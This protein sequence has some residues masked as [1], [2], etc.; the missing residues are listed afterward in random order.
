[1]TIENREEYKDV[2]VSAFNFS[3]RTYN[4][5]KRA[6]L[7]S[8][9]QVIANYDSLPDIRNMGKKS[10]D[11]I[12]EMLH[13]I[14]TKGLPVTTAE[15][16]DLREVPA[17]ANESV[18][19]SRPALPDNILQRPM[20]DLN[21]SVRVRNAL[22]T[23][24]IKTIAQ[25]MTLSHKEMLDMPR[26]GSLSAQL[27][28]EQLEVLCEMRENYFC[29]K[30][31]E[32]DATSSGHEEKPLSSKKNR[33]LDIYT[34]KKL[35]KDFGF[36]T[37]WLCEWY[38]IS[39]QRAY[40]KLASRKNHGRWCRKQLLPEERSIM[41]E[42]INAKR[43]YSEKM[44]VKYYFLNN[45]TDDCAFL[46]V[47]ED[48]IRCFFLNDLPE[49]L[50]ARIKLENLH[51]FTENEFTEIRSLGHEVYILKKKYF[52]PNDSSKFRNLA[53]ARGLSNEEYAQFLFK[54]PF[55]PSNTSVTDERIISF[56]EKNTYN[57]QTMIPSTPDNQW[58]RSYIS[59]SPFSTDEFIAFYG[60]NMN[61]SQSIGELDFAE[62]DF[63]IVESDMQIYDTGNDY[64][65]KIYAYSPLLGSRI[66]S[67]S[68][69]ERL[70][71]NSRKYIDQ[72][73]SN[74]GLKPNLKVEMQI[75][76]AVI[77]YAKDWDTEDETGFWRYITSQFGYRDETGQLRNLLCNCVK[78]ALIKNH[79]WFITNSNGNQFKSSIVVHALS[80]KRSWMYYCDFL[81][82]FYKTNLDWVY[83]EG[84][85]MIPRMILALRNKLL[86]SDEVSDEDI[87]ISAN[88]YKFRESI[89]KLVIHRPKYS[90]QLSATLIKR[91]D[92]LVNHT[93]TPAASYEEHLCDEWMIKK[94]QGLSETK[95]R[96]S[97]S[98]GRAVAIDYTR[99]RPYYSLRSERD[100]E[101]IF[102]DVRLA[103][104]NFSTLQ[105]TV[106]HGERAV[107]QKSLGFYGNE[108][109]RTMKGFSLNM[110]DYLRRSDSESFDPQVIISCD[111]EE[112][113]NSE[114]VL[115][116]GCLAFRNRTE[117]DMSSL[118]QGE[119]SF[120][121]PGSAKVEFINTE[122]T[123]IKENQYLKG[124]YLN[125]Q[126]DFAIHVNDMLAAFDN[127]QG[128]EALRIIIPGGGSDV[129]FIANG[130]YYTVV[131]GAETVHII[132]TEREDEKRYRLAVNNN[133]IDLQ[134]LPF[135]ESAGVRVYKFQ[136]GRLG[137][138][139]LT[140]R[141]ID[142]ANDRLILRR[143]Y[144][145]IKNL[146]YRFN[147]PYYFT[148]EEY[149]EAKIRFFDDKGTVKEYSL[150]P[151]DTRI[152]I[153]YRTG[154][155]EIPVPTIKVI[156]N[157]NAEWDG[158]NQYWIK[159]IPQERFLYV[160]AKP[161]LSVAVLLEK[162]S[163]GTESAN[164]FALGNAI[165]GYSDTEGKEWL[166]VYLSVSMKDQVTQTYLLGKIA[167]KEQF[168]EK[169]IIK[170]EDGKLRWNSGYGFIG[171]TSGCFKI[172]ICDG[173][174]YEKHYDLRLN[175]E[176]IA[177]DLQIPLG[178]YKYTISKQS[179]NLFFLQLIPITSGSFCVGDINELRFL[180]RTIQIDT[181]TFEDSTKSAAVKIRPCFIDK[182]EYKGLQY[183]GSEDRKCP[184]YS[185]ILY[186]ISESGKRHE[187]SYTD[188]T[189]GKGH[190]LYQMNP[191]KIVYI[192][193]ST[194]SLTQDTGDGFYYNRFF[195]KRT[196]TN[197]YQL[198]DW[199]PTD[200]TKGNYYLA[201]LYSYTRKGESSDV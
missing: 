77:N 126:K 129:S 157:A 34:A 62:E 39:R 108:L 15:N 51:R 93:E 24:G 201:D 135:E 81:F 28:Q 120:F 85:P 6:R 100:I 116:R 67:E 179:G 70:N 55:C 45:M 20:T 89:I 131:S 75:A 66:L 103:Q 183:V 59:R 82:D 130:L 98:E 18:A 84:D 57:G 174:E 73:L 37:V 32:E 169:P 194:L 76:L 198:T 123:I 29:A 87:Q 47:S 19:D 53:S 155:L 132:S 200:K 141:M 4:C 97:S 165:Y 99:I 26:M 49:A 63:A 189:D 153:P 117:A 11:E 42:M 9:Y 114:K 193:D 196:M 91:I 146:S 152:R 191:V 133:M 65:E 35:I 111:N 147:R 170:V 187:Y 13:S 143:N 88:A 182:I 139:E 173:T 176:L 119:Y 5:L 180:N 72:L 16:D 122:V 25:V 90:A 171:D 1:M 137:E 115:V 71:Q 163:I 164:V 3:T 199:E 125:L 74:S 94:L 195:D 136:I 184:V 166:R 21:V 36:K 101:I 69:K 148:S 144:K 79:R 160:K 162:Q 40:Q 124:Y 175:E 168:V 156:D 80:P 142:L 10:M 149:K 159:D 46:V 192:N 56:L 44:A 107:I 12:D 128:G 31:A 127:A 48:D 27:L 145:I 86:E 197:V 138:E 102:P 7:D 121:L 178:E 140:V 61:D 54:L 58:I 41:T 50:Q 8:L 78:D 190:L 118:E 151:G 113:Y 181:I 167:V 17:V 172:T 161:G 38:G 33:E 43:F 64:V 186:F 14:E 92:A 105:L 106:Y 96:D 110:E 109:G 95:R 104:N 23:N 150:S 134:S 30:E 68:N 52:M 22:Q 158:S 112:I 83:V 60:F 2:A 188:K 177:D 185:G 154:E